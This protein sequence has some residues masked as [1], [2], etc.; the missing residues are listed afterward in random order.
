[1]DAVSDESSDSTADLVEAGPDRPVSPPL[2][3]REHRRTAPLAPVFAAVAL[4]IVVDR[5]ASP[6]STIAWVAA[7]AFAAGLASLVVRRPVV[8][9]AAILL[10]VT[11]LGGGW[12]HYRWD[13]L[14]PLDLARSLSSEPSPAWVRGV[15][16]EA[17]GLRESSG[18]GRGERVV[19]SRF[20][21]ELSAVNDRGAWRPARGRAMMSVVGETTGIRAGQAVEA[22]GRLRR[23]PGPLN[24][25]EFD[26]AAYLRGQGIRLLL[27]IDEPEGLLPDPNS[28]PAWI[29]AVLGRLRAFS[30]ARLVERID[31]AIEPLVAGL[32][33]GQREGIDPEVSDAFARTGTTHL[34]AISGLHLQVLA[35]GLVFAF[36][37][38]GVAR[39]PAHALVG[40]GALSYAVLVGLA[41]SVVRSTMMTLAF[42]LAAVM[43]RAV[44]PSNT[45][46]LA[47]LATLAIN[48][49]NL[50][51]VGCQLSF[52]AVAALFWLVPVA[53]VGG[54]ALVQALR[55]VIRGPDTPLDL[56]ERKYHPK[57]RKDLRRLGGLLFVGLLTSTV[58]WLAAIP[59][60]SLRFHLI[61]P[62]GVLLNIP[63]I[64]ITS[65]ALLLGG[66]GLAASSVWGPLGDYPVWAAA[67]LLWLTE[68]IVR[69]GAAQPWGHTF[70]AGPGWA[71]VLGFYAM[72]ALAALTHFMAPRAKP[73][74]PR[75]RDRRVLARRAA[76]CLPALWAAT[77]P[78]EVREHWPRRLEVEILAVGHGLAVLIATPDGGC[79]LYDCGRMGDP[80]VG[81]RIVAPALWR[82]GF[83]RI[84]HVFLSHADSDHYDGLPDL[85]DRFTIGD[86][87]TQAE[88]EHSRDPSV[89]DLLARLARGGVR[90]RPLVAGVEW[91]FE[92]VSFRVLH[93]PEGWA[94]EASDNERSLVLEIGYQGRSVLLTGDLERLGLELLLETPPEGAPFDLVVSPHHGAR[95][96]N[97]TALFAWSR[98]RIV[99]VSQRSPV[100]LS[101][102]D[103]L[104]VLSDQGARVARTWRDGAVTIALGR[105]DVI[106]H[107]FLERGRPS[108]ESG[109]ASPSA[110]ER[111]A[112]GYPS[113]S[114]SSS[115][116]KMPSMD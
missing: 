59:L 86:V 72:L 7:A 40:T 29:A 8:S 22:A 27:T 82:R 45:L 3:R 88:F 46:A 77:W 97:P 26:Y 116:R 36:R 44:R 47:G 94:P 112:S 16:I 71:W 38:L 101:A 49:V 50:F 61:S 53:S 9:H 65:T 107:D 92:D 80:S 20:V 54:G 106:E 100:A 19:T 84:D 39:G 90:T 43:H 48:P 58:V 104:A 87:F 10:A 76:W 15:I 63:L 4:G 28:R 23:A 99:V 62:I 75:L 18:F 96:A 64:P 79:M 78:F 111:R 32:L 6:C 74:P 17:L 33:L 31:P 24:P 66:I 69:W 113:S 70:V 37:L 56:L 67:W 12:H 1:M 95:A 98:P 51:D 11:A 35:A 91:R 42:C 85:L 5:F 41:P 115:E 89:H 102:V 93:P 73:T 52:L 68:A 55:T 103:A 14:D 60:V 57:W 108:G 81:R 110:L 2:D 105:E 83:T 114:S 109:G 25:G 21:L 34:L 30:R 13:D